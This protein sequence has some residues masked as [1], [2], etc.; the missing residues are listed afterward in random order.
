LKLSR[1][2]KLRLKRLKIETTHEERIMIDTLITE[3]TGERDCD[4]AVK[5]L[6]DE[7]FKKIVEEAKRIVRE[8]QKL[9]MYVYS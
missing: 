6:T 5:K 4:E 8:K 7:E 3:K 9:Q 2:V 1:L